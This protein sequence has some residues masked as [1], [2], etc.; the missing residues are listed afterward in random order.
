M[1]KPLINTVNLIHRRL[2]KK[3]THQT[4]SN[5]TSTSIQAL[6]PTSQ[7]N[8]KYLHKDTSQT[9]FKSENHFN[10]NTNTNINNSFAIKINPYKTSSVKIPCKF[11]QMVQEMISV[12]KAYDNSSKAA[13]SK[14]SHHRKRS[15]CSSGGN[16]NNNCNYYNNNSELNYIFTNRFEN[17]LKSARV[18]HNNICTKCQKRGKINNEDANKPKIKKKPNVEIQE[19]INTRLFSPSPYKK[20]YIISRLSSSTS[21]TSMRRGSVQLEHPKMYKGPIDLQMIF[22]SQNERTFMEKVVS[23]LKKCKISYSKI[24]MF[25]YHCAKNGDSFNLEVCS[26]LWGV[27]KVFVICIKSQK[28]NVQQNQDCFI[29]ELLNN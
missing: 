10:T 3:K 22:V 23:A 15:S 19:Y 28:G 11:K 13:H 2:L 16:N 20:K 1:S 6:S 24:N 7:T 5:N 18:Q 29:K 27:K 14:P 9:S 17:P 12:K 26:I 4:T 8:I 25:K 21:R